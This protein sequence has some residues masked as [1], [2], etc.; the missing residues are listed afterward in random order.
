AQSPEVARH[1]AAARVAAGEDLRPWL[2]LGQAATPA[3]APPPSIEALMAQPP[4]PP[5]KAFDNLAFVGAKWVSAWALTTSDGIILLDALN[6]EDEAERL[7]EGGLRRLG[8]DPA[9]VKRVVVTHGHGDHYG[10]ATWL[11]QRHGAQV[12]M[13]GA[14]WRMLET[15][16]EFDVPQWGRPPR[17]D[18]VVEDGDSIRLGDTSVAVLMTPGHSPGTISLLFDVLEGQRRHRALLWGGTAFNF[19]R[20]PDR[21]ERIDS[22]I[23]ATRR[24]KDV[25]ARENVTVLLSNHSGY[26]EADR[27]LQRLQPGAANPFVIGQEAVQRTLTIIEECALATQAAWRS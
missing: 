17:R 19:G 24:A 11:K 3:T 4:P 8:L 20:R 10:G 9:Q 23:A 5:A 1:L 22:Y 27:K 6:N 7:I 2:A 12:A 18:V 25:A 14:D 16:L 26:D 15:E 13:S 21:M